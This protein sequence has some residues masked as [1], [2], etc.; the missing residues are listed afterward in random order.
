M[1]PCVALFRISPMMYRII[2]NWRWKLWRFLQRNT[3]SRWAVMRMRIRPRSGRFFHKKSKRWKK[4]SNIRKLIWWRFWLDF[5]VRNRLLSVSI[6]IWWLRSWWVW[7]T[8]ILTRKWGTLSCSRWGLES[9]RYR[10]ATLLWKMSR[11]LRKM[12]LWF[13][14]RKVNT[15]R[16]L[17]LWVN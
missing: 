3:S 10:F 13:I 6:R 7:K 5:T 14:R 2:P 9:Q 1:I 15:D 12:M 16:E 4:G 11:I 8:I 17:F